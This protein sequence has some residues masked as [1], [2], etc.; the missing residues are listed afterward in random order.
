MLDTTDQRAGRVPQRGGPWRPPTSTHHAR[1]R[2]ASMAPSSQMLCLRVSGITKMAMR[3]MIAGTAMGYT[4][5]QPTLP[6]ERNIDVVTM[7]TRPPPQPLPMWYG[8][9]TEV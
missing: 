6:V 7:G 1:A 2:V 3:N 4:S 9:E 8:T 5:A